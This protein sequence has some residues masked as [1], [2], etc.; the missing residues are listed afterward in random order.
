MRVTSSKHVLPPSFQ[1]AET[2]P[3]KA[4]APSGSSSSSLSLT[5]TGE[6]KA[7]TEVVNSADADVMSVEDIKS[8][9]RKGTYEPDMFRVADK[10]VAGRYV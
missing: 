1:T 9:L 10:L 5:G 2:E 4:S 7:Y 6:L 3:T 8:S